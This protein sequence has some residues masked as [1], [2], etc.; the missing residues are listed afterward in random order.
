M[1]LSCL[2][3]IICLNVFLAFWN[4]N[5]KPAI[6][7]KVSMLHV[8]RRIMSELYAAIPDACSRVPP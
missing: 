8:A 6:R 5:L 1:L 3:A 4:R 7:Q 2:A